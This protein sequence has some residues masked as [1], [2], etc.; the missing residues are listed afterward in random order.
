MERITSSTRLEDAYG[1]N[2]DG[3]TEGTP[4]VTPPTALNASWFGNVQEEIARAV[5]LLGGT[6]DG[7]DMEQLGTLL[8]A[9]LAAKADGAASSTDNAIAR[10][11]LATGKVIQNSGVT[12]DDS[13]NVAGAANVTIS[14]S[15]LYATPPTKTLKILGSQLEGASGA[16]STH[17]AGIRTLTT[18]SGNYQRQIFLP[19]GSII[20]TIRAVVDPGA[21]RAGANRMSCSL[22]KRTSM[23]SGGSPSYGS[24]SVVST[25][26]DNAGALI[27]V[28]T[29]SAI[30]ETVAGDPLYIGIA[31]GNDAGVSNDTVGL[32]E[33]EYTDAGPKNLG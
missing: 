4:G 13:N 14:G 20:T 6:L 26:T 31:A 23:S 9:A 27:Q 8:V 28:I 18:N 29:L 30:N 5:E 21:A 19:A 24:T 33:I 7:E 22:V 32:I 11:H 25:N 15:F 16:A 1:A 12:I 2:R 3:F 10:F 17:T